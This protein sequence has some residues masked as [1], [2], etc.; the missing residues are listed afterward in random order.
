M[1]C[2]G[3]QCQGNGEAPEAWA[4]LQGMGAFWWS[5]VLAF[6]DSLLFCG[7]EAHVVTSS[8]LPGPRERH[9]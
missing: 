8:S 9:L 5:Q 4:L 7:Q 3:E 2:V 1:S 6:H